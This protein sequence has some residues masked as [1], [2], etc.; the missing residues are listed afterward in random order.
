MQV[1]FYEFLSRSGCENVAVERAFVCLGEGVVQPL[2]E[3]ERLVQRWVEAVKEAQ[4]ELV[5]AL[6]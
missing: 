3:A 5:G 6:E 1:A 4:L 2:P